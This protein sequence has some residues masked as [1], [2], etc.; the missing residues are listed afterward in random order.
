MYMVR[1][2][3]PLATRMGPRHTWNWAPPC[4]ERSSGAVTKLVAP[5]SVVKRGRSTSPASTPAMADSSSAV[6]PQSDRVSSS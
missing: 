6:G 3:E 4:W 5:T 2:P 1:V